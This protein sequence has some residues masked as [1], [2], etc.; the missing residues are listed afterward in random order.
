L[1]FIDIEIDIESVNLAGMARGVGFFM[2][3]AEFFL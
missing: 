1:R 2:P 3:E